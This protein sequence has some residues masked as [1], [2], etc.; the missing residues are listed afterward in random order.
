MS[1]WKKLIDV[2]HYFYKIILW[3]SIQYVC[4]ASKLTKYVC[5]LHF[6]CWRYYTEFHIKIL[7]DYSF[8]SN[9]VYT[10]VSGYWY[11][12]YYYVVLKLHSRWYFFSKI[13]S[14]HIWKKIW[15]TCYVFLIFS[16]EYHRENIQKIDFSLSSKIF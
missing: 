11:G 16:L 15:H 7:I 5:N 8:D 12:I 10:L 2:Y 9:R 14:N 3:T 13:F 4:I 6:R 1:R